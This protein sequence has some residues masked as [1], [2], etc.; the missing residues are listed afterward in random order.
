MLQSPSLD[1][2]T[3]F[4]LELELELGK[5]ERRCIGRL[6]L[7][8]NAADSDLDDADAFGLELNAADLTSTQ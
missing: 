6:G 4:N 5:V 8:F 2:Y 3:S 1:L 7:D